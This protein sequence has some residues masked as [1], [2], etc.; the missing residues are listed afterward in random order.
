MANSFLFVEEK[1]GVEDK[2]RSGD[3]IKACRVLST[4]PRNIGFNLKAT[5]GH[6]RSYNQISN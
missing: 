2:V 4:K 5:L 1:S 3:M 6:L